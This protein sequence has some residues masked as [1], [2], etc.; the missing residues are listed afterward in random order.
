MA[1]G[2]LRPILRVSGLRRNQRVETLFSAS[3]VGP[4]LL[5]LPVDRESAP[6]CALPLGT[7]SVAP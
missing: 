4:V 5:R 1:A 6:F 7:E 3:P 2:T